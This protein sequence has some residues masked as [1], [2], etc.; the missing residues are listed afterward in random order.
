MWN[1]CNLCE[2]NIKRR[3]CLHNHPSHRLMIKCLT[4]TQIALLFRK[5]GIWGKGKPEQS[6]C[7]EPTTNSTHIH[8]WRW[9]RESSLRHI[10]TLTTALNLLP[11]RVF[12][13][14][15]IKKSQLSLS[16]EIFPSPFNA[17]LNAGTRRHM[18]NAYGTRKCTL[19]VR[20][21]HVLD[22]WSLLGTTNMSKHQHF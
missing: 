11:Q 12:L 4:I 1:K 2:F 17:M 20:L 19:V 6:T 16:T 8:V 13:H 15:Q 22:R 7:R 18:F 9:V 10:G 5:I 14:L 21:L 3:G